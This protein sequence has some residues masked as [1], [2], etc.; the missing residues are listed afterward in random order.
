VA[1]GFG[2]R[3]IVDDISEHA[4]ERGDDEFAV[5]SVYDTAA[6]Y[7]NSYVPHIN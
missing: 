6:F 3:P 1:G 5:Q 7:I 4:S 2:A